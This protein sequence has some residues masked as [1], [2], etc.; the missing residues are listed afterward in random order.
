MPAGQFFAGSICD[1]PGATGS[2]SA[3]FPA[4][5]VPWVWM[6]FSIS[7]ERAAEKDCANVV[8]SFLE[9]WRCQWH[10]KVVF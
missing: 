7:E 10:K 1:L 6:A 2:A 3:N 4:S 8:V 9:H 5:I